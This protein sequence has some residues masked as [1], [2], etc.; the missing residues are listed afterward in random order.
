[1]YSMQFHSYGEVPKNVADE[2]IQKVRGG[3]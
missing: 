3:E 1:V 2:I